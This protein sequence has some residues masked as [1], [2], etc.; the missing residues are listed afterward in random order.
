M[1]HLTVENILMM[2]AILVVTAMCVIIAIYGY[3]NL[4]DKN[5]SDYLLG[6]GW[7]DLITGI[8]TTI[9][10]LYGLWHFITC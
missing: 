9:M 8:L 2:V 7:G 4:S 5:N 6:Q 10:C 3:L 1:I